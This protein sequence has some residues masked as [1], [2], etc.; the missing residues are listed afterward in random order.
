M[1]VRVG[2]IDYRRRVADRDTGGPVS[3]M[4]ANDSAEDLRSVSA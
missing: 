4:A 3:S 2:Y 1:L